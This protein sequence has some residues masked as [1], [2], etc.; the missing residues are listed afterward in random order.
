MKTRM[1][2][3]FLALIC[4]A[5][6]AIAAEYYI[7]DS[8][9]VGDIYCTAAGHAANDGKTPATPKLEINNLLATYTLAPGDIVHIDAG[10]YTE[11]VVIPNTVNGAEGSHITFQGAPSARYAESLSVFTPL[12]NTIAF[13]IS[14]NYLH[15]KD[16]QTQGGSRGLS[17]SASSH[18]EYERI[19]VT[20][21]LENPLLAQ[22]ASNNN[23]FR[24]CLF[25]TTVVAAGI[26]LTGSGNY[27]EY[28]TAYSPN[29]AAINAGGG[30]LTNIYS[31][32]LY[33]DRVAT[34]PDAIPQGG[35]RNVLWGNSYTFGE[36]ETLEAFQIVNTNWY[37]NTVADPKF[38]DT[39]NWDFHV[40]SASG[41]VSNGVWITN[42]A[43]GYSPAIDYGK[44]ED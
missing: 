36:Y 25:A 7:N 37:S 3:I 2:C 16:I 8:S 31:S 32:I 23:A 18:G 43:V 41:F 9:Q 34:T 12:G 39:A 29:G 40:K 38:A 35:S 4:V 13:A 26:N 33:G 19:R 28:C 20:G 24:H 21:T 5:V 42:A 14:G 11:N 1:F 17:L 30:V 15:F 6:G 27:I 10:T 22:G 44:K